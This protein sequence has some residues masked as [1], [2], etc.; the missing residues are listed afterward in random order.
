MD[1]Y[2]SKH[3]I[4]LNGVPVK[5]LKKVGE[6]AQKLLLEISNDAYGREIIHTKVAGGVINPMFKK[7]DKF[8]CG[9][10]RGV[11]MICTG[12]V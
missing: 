11:T 7:G 10:Y 3:D 4:Y 2:S 1:N 9:N 6:D 12:F 8:C 5:I